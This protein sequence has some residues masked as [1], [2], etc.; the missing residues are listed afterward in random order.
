M[1]ESKRHHPD[2]SEIHALKAAGRRERAAIS[3]AEKLDAVDRLKAGIEPVVRA[4][5]ERKRMQQGTNR[6]ER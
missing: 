1:T 6:H 5:E 2:N 4:R 3:F